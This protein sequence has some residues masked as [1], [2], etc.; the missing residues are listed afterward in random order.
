MRNTIVARAL[1]EL[2]GS[3]QAEGH[4]LAAVPM[5]DHVRLYFGDDVDPSSLLD[6]SD[7][8]VIWSRII[9]DAAVLG[10]ASG[11]DGTVAMPVRGS[12][13][14]IWPDQ[15]LSEVFRAKM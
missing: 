3:S 14:A 6:Q 4:L 7:D 5:E 8:M 15:D 11:P 1:S 9:G 12:S 13:R 10:V 2:C